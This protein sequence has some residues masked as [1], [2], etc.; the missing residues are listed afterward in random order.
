MTFEEIDRLVRRANP[1]PDPSVLEPLSTT[2]EADE[3]DV[4]RGTAMQIQDLSSTAEVQRRADARFPS[5]RF[6]IVAAAAAVIVVALVAVSASTGSDDDGSDAAAMPT[7]A[8]TALADSFVANLAEHD[9]AGAMS[10]LTADSAAAHDDLARDLRW[11]EATGFEQSFDGCRE[12]GGGSDHTIVRCSFAYHG[13][14]SAELGL[15][16]Y[17]GSSY[18]IVVRDGRIDGFVEQL[19]F[20]ENGFNVE[21]WEP[22]YE[23]LLA[24]HR[25]DVSVM[26]TD[27]SA[28]AHSNTD[29][30]IALWERRS[31]E[32][33]EAAR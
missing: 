15:G 19:E 32:Y 20:E 27:D 29:E 10:Y 23:W 18:R 2:D 31:Q 26:F 16:P 12:V 13:L 21:V 28:E 8:P 33:V 24:N 22:F 25:G 17:E 11:A 9:A 6:A 1:V 3:D 5:G 7:V 30:S 4:R 14:R